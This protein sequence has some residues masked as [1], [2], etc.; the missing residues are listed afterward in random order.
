MARDTDLNIIVEKFKITGRVPSAQQQPIA[1]DFTNL[2][3]DL[4]G[5]IETAKSIKDC[6]AKL[7][8]N[9]GKCPSSSYWR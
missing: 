8:R 5:F 4:R 3:D 6:R 2:P 9:C 7:P 1:G